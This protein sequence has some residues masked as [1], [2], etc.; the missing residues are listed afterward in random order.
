[1]IKYMEKHYDKL[2][3]CTVE[4]LIISLLSVL[5][6]FIIAY[7]FSVIMRK[8]KVFDTFMNGLC[9]AIFAIPSLAM[10][11]ILIPYSGLGKNTAII[12]LVLYNQFILTKSIVNAFKSVPFEIVEAS[13]GMGMSR[14]QRY[15]SIQ[16][17]LALPGILSGLKLSVISTITMASLAATIGGGGIGTLLF[18]GLSMKNYNMVYWGIILTTLL[19]FLSGEV[20][21]TL[22]KI[23]RK[24]A[25]G[26]IKR[27]CPVD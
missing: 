7:A 22:E 24:A 2:I 17:P 9:D 10:F 27:K 25:N 14:I 20:L 3:D 8:S 18:N 26:E 23:A 21:G 1:M 4:H 15:I 16:V 6:A 12:A 11:A 19:A 13:K 5:I